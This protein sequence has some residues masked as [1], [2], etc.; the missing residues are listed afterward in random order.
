MHYFADD[1]HI[2]LAFEFGDGGVY[3]S[4]QPNLLFIKDTDGD[5]KADFRR[6]IFSGF[7]TEDSHHSLHDFVRTPDGDLLFRE[8]VFHNSQVETAYG[9][10]RAK[11][12]AWFQYHPSTHKLTSFGNYHNTNPWGATF[13]DWGFHIASHPNFASSFHATNPPYPQQHPKPAGIDA[14][15]GTCG[16]EVVDFDTFP[17]E[18]QGGVIKVRYKPT[19]RIEIHKWEEKTAHYKEKLETNLLFAKNLSFIP[20]DI[21]FGPRGALYICDWY[22]PVKGHAQYSLRDERRDRTAGRIWRVTT[23]GKKLQDAPK[24][25]GESLENLLELLKRKEYRVRYWA[26]RRSW[27]AMPIKSKL[28]CKSG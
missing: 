6:V 13:D 11:N 24:I 5:G 16:Q 17:E 25:A 20:V 27:S 28:Q 21:R 9:P 18:L 2:P 3:V 7:G 19:N 8:S 22:N 10:V 1:L 14:Y 23:K 4:D 12:S 15:S 26:K